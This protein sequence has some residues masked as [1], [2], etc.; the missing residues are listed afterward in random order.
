MS[1]N[2]KRTSK[3]VASKAAEVLQDANASQTQKRLAASALSQ[4]ADKKQTSAEMEQVAS[5]VLKSPRYSKAT[6][7]LAATVL[8]QSNKER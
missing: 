6:K 4:R 8:S 7:S 5:E 3:A 2:T 1:S